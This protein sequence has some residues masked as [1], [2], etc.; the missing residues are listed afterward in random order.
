[1]QK[2]FIIFLLSSMSI[3][4]EASHWHS[5]ETN[6]HFKTGMNEEQRVALLQSDIDRTHHEKLPTNWTPATFVK[7]NTLL[8]ANYH[9]QPIT[10]T[11]YNFKSTEK[12]RRYMVVEP[13][14]LKEQRESTIENHIGTNGI[15]TD[16]FANNETETTTPPVMRLPGDDPDDPGWVPIGDGILPLLLL[17]AGYTMRSVVKRRH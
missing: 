2:P 15:T 14:S 16:L 5:S 9:E 10:E 13:I 6:L 8:P 7:K 11:N 12:T 3:F 4:V 1:M 17:S